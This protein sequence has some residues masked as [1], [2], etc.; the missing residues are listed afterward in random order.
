MLNTTA[1]MSNQATINGKLTPLIDTEKKI[2]ETN[3]PSTV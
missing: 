2:R 3:G 1:A